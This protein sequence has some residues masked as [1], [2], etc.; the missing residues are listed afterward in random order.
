MK[1]GKKIRLRLFNDL[2]VFYGTIDY[3]ELKSIYIN[4]Q[5]WI[6]PKDDYSNWKKIVCTQSRDIKH[7]ILDVNDLD[8]F[9]ESTIVDLDIRHSG[10]SLDKKSF[11]N[12]EITLFVKDGVLFKS[13]EMKDG[14]KKIIK[15]IYNK[16][17]SKNKYFDFYLTKKEL[18]V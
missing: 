14:I 1:N 18:S 17:I 9:Y 13:Q 15:Q 6:S 12:L 8:L 7:T 10:I 2:K 4:I 3:I 16:N 5:S 11:M